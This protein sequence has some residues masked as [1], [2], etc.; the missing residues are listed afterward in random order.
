MQ[1]LI[2][3]KKENPQANTK[4]F[5]KENERMGVSHEVDLILE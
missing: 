3:R 4:N 2:P 1:R 5:M